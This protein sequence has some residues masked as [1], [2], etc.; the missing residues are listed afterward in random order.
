MPPH[1]FPL[2]EMWQLSLALWEVVRWWCVYG[3]C[4]VWCYVVRN[5]DLWCCL[6]GRCYIFHCVVM[7]GDYMQFQID[8]NDFCDVSDDDWWRYA[9]MVM[10]NDVG[11]DDDAF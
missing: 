10:L 1:T 11:D 6:A 5:G 9:V 4:G 8:Y 3:E 2:S 7:N